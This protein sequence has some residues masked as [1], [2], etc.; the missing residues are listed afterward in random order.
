LPIGIFPLGQLHPRARKAAEAAR[1]ANEQGKFWQY[2][3]KLYL[4]GADTS[5]EKLR[6]LAQETGMNV[7]IFEQCFASGKHGVRG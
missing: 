6:A 4:G 7:S 3:D 2:H 5:P 1:C